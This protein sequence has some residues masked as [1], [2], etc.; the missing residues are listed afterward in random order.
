MFGVA[1]RRGECIHAA[2]PHYQTCFVEHGIRRARQAD[3]VV[4]NHA[5]VLSQAAWAALAPPGLP[6]EDTTPR[7][8]FSTK[9]HHIPDA[10]DSAFATAL[11]GL[12]AAELRRWLLG[13]EG[14]RSAPGACN[15]GW[16]IW[17]NACR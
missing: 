14:S 2:C 9:G 10:A 11:S 15:A 3:L 16:T 6:D 5:L 17:S 7:A 4:A 12:E 13:A 1:D 8:T